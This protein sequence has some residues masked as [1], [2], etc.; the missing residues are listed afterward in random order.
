MRYFKLNIMSSDLFSKNFLD[1]MKRQGYRAEII[2]ETENYY[3]LRRTDEQASYWTV[4]KQWGIV[5]Y[6]ELDG[7]FEL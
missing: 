4:K 7:M 6:D 3:H 5:E 1:D 2:G